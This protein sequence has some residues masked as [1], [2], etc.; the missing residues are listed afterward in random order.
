MEIPL[1]GSY[2]QQEIR[3]AVLLNYPRWF[4]VLPVLSLVLGGFVLAAGMFTAIVTLELE[5]LACLGSL[6][7]LFCICALFAGLLWSQPWLQARQV[8]KS[9]LVQGDISG[10]ATDE[11][12]E[13]RNDLS[14]SRVLWGAFVRHKMSDDMVILYQHKTAFNMVPRSFLASE[15]DW[16]RFQRLVQEVVPAKA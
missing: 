3:K 6:L 5:P 15:E 9:P 12:L 2:S 1:K 13:M 7:P 4:R 8:A 14:E 10:V 16:Q 11:A